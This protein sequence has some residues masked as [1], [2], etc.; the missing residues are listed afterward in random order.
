MGVD[1]ILGCWWRLGDSEVIGG[2]LGW[3]ILGLG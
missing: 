2:L 1:R 3:W